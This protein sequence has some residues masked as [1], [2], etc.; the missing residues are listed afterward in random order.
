MTLVIIRRQRPTV[1]TSISRSHRAATVGNGVHFMQTL[2]SRSKFDAEN[3]G[4]D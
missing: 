2:G 4:A 3:D 1:I